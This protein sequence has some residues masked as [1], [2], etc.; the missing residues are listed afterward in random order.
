MSGIHNL[1]LVLVSLKVMKLQKMHSN[2][3]KL[4]LLGHYLAL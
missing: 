4:N 3:L 1:L 2:I